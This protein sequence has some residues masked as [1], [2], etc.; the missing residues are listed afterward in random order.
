MRTLESRLFANKD[1]EPF[2]CVPIKKGNVIIENK[3]YGQYAGEIYIALQDMENSG[4]TNVVGHLAESE[5]D[6]FPYLKGG[7]QFC[8]T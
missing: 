6:L 8:F 2:N 4:R 1:I 5:V 3:N 7:Q